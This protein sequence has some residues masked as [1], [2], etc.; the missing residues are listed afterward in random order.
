M[1]PLTSAIFCQFAFAPAI[2][3]SPAGFLSTASN[4]WQKRQ[5]K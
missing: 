3:T 4:H 1:S 2:H 5:D